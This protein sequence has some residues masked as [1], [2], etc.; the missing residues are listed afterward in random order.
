MAG[1]LVAA[2][3]QILSRTYFGSHGQKPLD[4]TQDAVRA[5]IRYI[6]S[7]YMLDL[8]VEELAR[9]FALSRSSFA[10]LFPQMAGMPVK[11][12][13][14]RRRIEQARKLCSVEGL[15]LREIARLVGYE[16][17]STFYRNFKKLTGVSPAEYR[18]EEAKN[19]N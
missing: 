17:F 11:Q 19:S 16:D 14:N 4:Q 15:P 2:M 12:Y 6:D 7:N 13:V 1:S 5:C 8:N 3:L 9:R 10:A 18:N